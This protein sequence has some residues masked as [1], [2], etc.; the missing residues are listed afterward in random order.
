MDKKKIV[1]ISGIAVILLLVV[2]AIIFFYTLEETPPVDGEH[3]LI[4]ATQRVPATPNPPSNLEPF[5]EEVE[6]FGIAP[7]ALGDITITALST[8]ALGVATDSTFLISS[9]VHTLTEEH[10]RSYLSVRSGE[11]FLLEA[12]PDNAFL[13]SFEEQLENNQVYNLVYHPPGRQ[14]TSHAFQTADIFRV[15]ATSPAHNTHG[16]PQEAGIE[17][18]FSQNLA[19]NFEDVFIIDPPV[20]GSFHRRDNNHHIFVPYSLEFSTRYTVTIPQGT[21]STTG[22]VLTEDYTFSFVTRWG[23][24]TIPLFSI[25]GNAYETFLPWDEVFIA[26][27]VSR[28]FEGREFYVD[29]YDL[30]TPENFI[31]FSEADS[32]NLSNPFASFE[33][34]LQEFRSEHRSFFYLFLEQTLPEG[35][36]VARVRSTQND[37]DIVQY[38]FIQ[39]SALSVYS[40]SV[41]AEVVFWV[42]DTTTGQPAQG[43][44]IRINTPT[45]TH[46][47]GTTNSDGV[48]IVEVAQSMHPMITIEYGNFSAF[49][50]TKPTFGNRVLRPN[51]KFLSY[52]Y[53]D[54]PHYRPNDTVDV[55]GVIKPRYGHS[56]L[57]T[58]EITLRIGDMI[59]LPIELDSHNSFLKRIPVTNMFGFMDIIVEIN[60]EILMSHWASFVD[61][62]NF[63]YVITG[64]LDRTAYFFGEYANVEIS[65][66]TFAGLP[67]EGVTLTSG[68]RDNSISITTAS[69]GIASR[70][71]PVGRDSSN[72]EPFW[73]SI[74]FSVSSAAQTSQSFVLPYIIVSRDIMMEHEYTGGDTLVLTTNEILIDRLNEHH[75]SA[76]AWTLIERDSFRG[77]VIDVDFE[78]H[79]T[80]HVT[81]RTIS[82]QSYDRINRRTV[83]TYSFNTES[84]PSYRVIPGRTENGTATLTGLP[85]SNDPLIRYSIEVRYYDTRGRETITRVF[86]NRWWHSHRQESSI[87]HFNL[88]L[89][90]RNLRINETTQ[91]SIV[92]V[93]LEEFDWDVRDRVLVDYTPITQGRLLTVLARD[94]VISATVG[95]PQGVPLTFTEVGISNKVLFGAY[96][97]GQYIFPVTNPVSVFYD[98]SE[99]ELQIE[100]EFDRERYQPGDEVTVNIQ[101]SVPAQVVI[102][103]VD[104]SSILSSWHEANFLS[105][106]YTSSWHSIWGFFSQFASHTQHNFGGAGDG[107]EGG[108]GDGNGYDSTFRDTFVDNPIFEIVQTDSNG[109]GSLTFTLPDQVTSWRVTAIGLTEDG[110]AGDTRYNIISHLDFYVD[111]LLTNEYIVGDDIAAVARVFGYNREPVTYIFN[112][113]QNNVLVFTDTQVSG[114]N[115]V[116]NAG[117]L[118]AGYYTMQVVAT[119]GNNS[120]A[121][122]LPFV[123]TESGGMI[124]PSRAIGQISDESNNSD[125]GAGLSFSNLPVRVTLTNANI[126]SLMNILNGIR[127]NRSYRTDYIAANDFI[128]YFFGGDS[129]VESVRS[130]IHAL[131]G[132]IPQLT[133]EYA[134]LYYTA[135]FAAS[136]PEFVDRD[137]LI[138]YIRAETYGLAVELYRQP[139][140][141]AAGLLALAAMGEPVLLD[142]HDEA[143]LLWDSWEFLP[144]NHIS[145]RN[146]ARLYLAAA[147]IAIGD[148]ASAKTLL[149]GQVL[150]NF[151]END[152]QR[153]STTDRE[154]VNT[155]LLFINTTLDPQVALEYINRRYAN[156]HVSDV[157][158]RINFVRRTYFM[159]ET[160]SEVQYYLNGA[161]HT[162]RLVNLDR[163]TLQLSKEQFD[164][165]NLIP[166]SGATDFHIEF[167]GYDAG[168]WDEEGNRI[169]IQRTI[170]RD[171]ELFRVDITVTMPPGT[172][173]SFTIYDRLPSNMRFVPLRRRWERGEPRFFVHN[174]QRQ[175][176]EVSFFVGHNQPLTRTISY[177]A[178]QLFEADMASS[179]TYISNG[180]AENHLW[181]MTRLPLISMN[182]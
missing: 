123:V 55:F 77:P 121:M 177:H 60:G 13:L 1:I 2:S 10:L 42:H 73:N 182:V 5:V 92:E 20:A 32:A 99:R 24:A 100:L 115:A 149:E 169:D 53:T 112:I 179:T 164:S 109:M 98:F 51:E 69:N 6:P 127:N 178:M 168:S 9:E 14:V 16:I 30:Q 75:A 130:R 86:D 150:A 157:P 82:S 29:V 81:T 156:E 78:V 41:E 173:G 90:N 175:L 155:L 7:S 65:V 27:N 141:R 117:K 39:V 33:L 37:I 174:T 172:V 15:T 122:E 139:I 52:M 21:A 17:I 159:G 26:I 31:N 153:L 58:D 116:F 70:S 54:R 94:G 93:G 120:D 114:R 49:A 67:V 62:T 125:I 170:V 11:E 102:S 85:V 61:Y 57:P 163:L 180:N 106:L 76:A 19:N 119:S 34:E 25:A 140:S 165:L 38:K 68:S 59:A 132:G 66:E 4:E 45:G 50:Y 134:D 135:R 28:D 47:S 104:E 80:Q 95:S 12:R 46:I 96:F 71:L 87:R 83:T 107:A 131:S 40:L 129:N 43:A 113:M 181:G 152:I 166:I 63:S 171:G 143:E 128:N 137:R 138:R 167:Y 161:T 84:I 3:R 8:T 136:F 151:L 88:V 158:E 126:S 64:E 142:I 105:R 144:P 147:Y 56:L 91:V 160:V 79:I 101:T 124:L 22:E 110:F 118:D 148:D 48:A 18:S 36:Y 89:E 108:G 74:W 145:T 154:T 97:D 111:L 176:V 72:W 35:Y 103:V 23:T 146:I 133:Y 44:Q 162:A